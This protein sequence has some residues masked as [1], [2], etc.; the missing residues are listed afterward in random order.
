LGEASRPALKEGKRVVEKKGGERSDGGAERFS[1][2]QIHDVHEKKKNNKDWSRESHQSALVRRE[3][4]VRV[5][6]ERPLEH[7]R[8]KKGE[9]FVK[10]SSEG[11]SAEQEGGFAVPR[12]RRKR[13]R[14]QLGSQINRGSTEDP[15]LDPKGAGKESAAC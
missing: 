10:W 15:Q 3:K 11:V 6:Q 7:F 2:S 8:S 4:K 5:T 14:A 9:V 12:R 13:L 1:G